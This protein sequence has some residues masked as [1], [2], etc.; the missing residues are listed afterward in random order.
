[1]PFESAIEVNDI[2]GVAHELGDE[3]AA[4]DF[5]KLAESILEANPDNCLKRRPALDRD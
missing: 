2:E 1:M 5:K 4:E 3:D